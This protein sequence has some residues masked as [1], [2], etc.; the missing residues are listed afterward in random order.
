MICS[1]SCQ[2]ATGGQG[3]AANR[4]H[5]AAVMM[6]TAMIIDDENMVREGILSLVDWEEEGF[7]LGTCGRD[8]REGLANILKENPDFVLVD[9]KM[10]GLTGLEVIR[11]ARRQ[12]F[13]GHFIILTGFSEFEYAKEAIS[14][15]VDGY[16]LKP[17]DEDEL[18]EYVKKIRQ[19]LDEERSLKRYH[20]QNED[21]ARQELL[22]RVV[23]NE[24][25]QKALQEDIA[26]Y[27]LTL[28]G[29]IFCVAVC[30]E[31]DGERERDKESGGLYDKVNCLIQGD[32]ACIG[33]FS[34]ED[35]VILIGRSIEYGLW[36]Q[37]LEKR[38]KRV[39]S[40]FGSGLKIAV[41]N[42]VKN[43]RELFCSYESARF[44]L[45]QAFI[46]DQDDILTID[47]ICGLKENQE[48]VTIEWMEMLIEVGEVDGIRQAL[49]VFRDYCTW[50]LLKEAEIKLLLIQDLIQLQ[51]RLGKKYDLPA[52]GNHGLQQLLKQLT[53][54]EDMKGLLTC[55]E[56][57]L[58]QLSQRIS[59]E[60]GGNI[61]RRVY[62]YI[63]KNYDKDLKLENIAKN[64]N[65]NSAYLG[66]LFRKEMGETFNNSLDR[67]RIT[68]ARRL[69]QETNLKVYQISQQVGYSS[70][71]YF[72]MKFKKY[73]GI[74]PKEY[75]KQVNTKEE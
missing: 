36:K 23:L 33:K 6:Y 17:V 72:Y 27:H 50:N 64:F 12:G 3:D 31:E 62:Y 68:N 59:A 56:Q 34:V 28:D 65:Y 57:I 53:A 70:M 49:K 55:Y 9:I 24:G 58:I 51:M 4:S 46:F 1:F 63:E 21:K 15:G 41:G 75:R 18:L 2:Q 22:R 26:L 35:Q 8:G 73:V 32:N 13:L 60:G 16:L 7:C 10:P 67:I 47:L 42:N 19:S 20:S 25:D 71:D 11:E 48:A 66:K 44:L 54:A 43:W 52:L 39:K 30:R 14:M 45:E 61:I 69:L 38:N 40:Y 29:D 37:R 74:S 5:G